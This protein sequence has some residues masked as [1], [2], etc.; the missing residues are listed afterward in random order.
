[1]A[2]VT[3]YADSRWQCPWTFHVMVAL[4]EMKLPY[5]LQAVRTPLA[6]EL[7]TE[8]QQHAILGNVPCLVDGDVWLTESIAISEYLSERYPKPPPL[9]PADVVERARARQVMLWV[10]TSMFALR[11]E[12][13]TSSVF[14]RPI[15]KPLSDR[16]RADATELVR[17]AEQL[18]PAGRTTLFA[19]WCIADIDLS[20][21]LMRLL[22]NSDPAM[23]KRLSDYALAQWD[24]KSVRRYLAY[25]PTTA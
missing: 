25:I 6:P 18:V 22:A 1:M 11:E 9:L 7:L 3:L 15:S 13:P 21:A 20:L 23:T 5:K 19:E 17:V 2:D 14:S 10:R 8:L 16:A 24:R 12:R 4:E